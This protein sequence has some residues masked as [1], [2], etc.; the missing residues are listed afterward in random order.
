MAWI[1]NAVSSGTRSW[2]SVNFYDGNHQLI[3]IVEPDWSG[4]EFPW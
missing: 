4:F 2:D 3:D 1:G